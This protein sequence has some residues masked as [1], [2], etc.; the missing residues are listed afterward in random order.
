MV[1]AV[2]ENRTACMVGLP[3]A[4]FSRSGGSNRLLSPSSQVKRTPTSEVTASA[5]G[6]AVN[7][8]VALWT[9]QFLHATFGEYLVARLT[10]HMLCDLQRMQAAQRLTLSQ[11]Q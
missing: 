3:L 9:Y 11:D 2:S 4:S 1:S 10:W 5:Q 7:D 8:M 6:E